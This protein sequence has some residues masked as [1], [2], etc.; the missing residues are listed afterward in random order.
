MREPRYRKQP[1]QTTDK[2]FE[3]VT[4]RSKCHC[5]KCGKRVKMHNFCVVV[6]ADGYKIYL[7]LKCALRMMIKA[8]EEIVELP[9]EPKR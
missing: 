4:C 1:I 3:V 2:L 6:G 9:G 7:H 8:I 5:K